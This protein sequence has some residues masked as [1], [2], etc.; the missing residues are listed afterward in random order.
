MA[1]T[2]VATGL[3]S[4]VAKPKASFLDEYERQMAQKKAATPTV[5]Q[6]NY[7]AAAGR[8]ASIAEGQPSPA[9]QAAQQASRETLARQAGNLRST[10][11]QATAA[12]GSL[13][14]GAGM[15]AAAST[16]QGIL[17]KIADSRLSERQAI[18]QEAIDANSQLVSGAQADRTYDFQKQ[19]Q[20]QQ[21][22]GTL[23]DKG[24]ASQQMEAQVGLQGLAGIAPNKKSDEINNAAYLEAVTDPKYLADQ[25]AAKTALID[26]Q[27]LLKDKQDEATRSDLLRKA[28]GSVEEWNTSVANRT[29]VSPNVKP[30]D[31]VKYNG[32][33]YIFVGRNLYD[34]Q[35]GSLGAAG[36]LLGQNSVDLYRTSLKDPITGEIVNIDD[37]EAD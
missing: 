11:A 14:Q 19:N 16:E 26:S 18:A 24:T 8:L 37:K 9:V 6:Q 17:G 12:S 3:G 1:D 23:L 30:G 27:T 29:K 13:G 5:F 4:L 32:K 20:Q 34:E 25:T 15:R 35:Y 36:S 2:T 21:L 33:P 7:D 10:T 28:A 31:I 22:L